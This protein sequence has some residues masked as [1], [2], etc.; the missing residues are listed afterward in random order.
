MDKIREFLFQNGEETYADFSA[1]LIPG[2]P[3]ECFIGVRVPTIKKYAKTINGT[4]EAEEFLMSIPHAYH[5]ENVLHASLIS[6]CKDY[7]KTLSLLESF[8]PYVDNWAVSD[9]ISPHVFKKHR[10]ELIPEIEKWTASETLYTRRFGVSM[11]MTHFLDEDFKPEYL[12]LPASLPAGEYYSDMMIAWYY[13]TALAKQWDSTVLYMEKGRL[14]E[15]IRRKSITKAVE[16]YRITSEQKEYL[17][18]LR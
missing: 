14:D 1:K 9:G 15:W 3:R 5:E 17:K 8:L 2:V 11:L 4:K 7:R 18:S 16:S 13:A 10:E 6:I 12:A